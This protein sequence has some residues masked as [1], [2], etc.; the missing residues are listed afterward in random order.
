MK[1][2]S[3]LFIGG[4]FNGS[5]CLIPWPWYG[6]GRV[7]RPWASEEKDNYLAEKAEVNKSGINEV[8]SAS[9]YITREFHLEGKIYLIATRQDQPTDSISQYIRA[10][11]HSPL[12]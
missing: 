8:D 4:P 2:Q 10:Q 9:E 3:V 7:I 6:T 12:V 11:N 1:K 5:S